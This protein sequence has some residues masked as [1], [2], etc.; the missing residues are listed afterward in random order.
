MPVSS[1]SQRE[2]AGAEEQQRC[3]LG[4]WLEI[5]PNSVEFPDR[6]AKLVSDHV[7]RGG[8]LAA[9][10]PHSGQWCAD[11]FVI[12]KDVTWDRRNLC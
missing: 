12:G 8:P 9:R 7:E 3:P 11:G 6:R 4:Y 5:V 1:A 2:H 10:S